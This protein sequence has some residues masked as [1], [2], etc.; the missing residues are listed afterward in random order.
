[1]PEDDARQGGQVQMEGEV[2]AV[3]GDGGGGDQ[4]AHNPPAAAL[5][6]GVGVEDQPVL[7]LGGDAHPVADP[8]LPGEIQGHIEPV[9]PVGADVGDDVVGGVV[10]A[11]PAEAAGVVVA[12]PEGGMLQIE[13]VGVAE[14]DLMLPEGLILQQVPVHG[15]A[16]VPVAELTE[17]RAHH[18]ELLAGA[19]QHIEVEDPDAGELLPVLPG[20]NVDEGVFLVLLLV[21][22]DGENEALGEGVFHGPGDVPVAALTVD[23][24][25]TQVVETVSHPAQIPFEG[26]AQGLLVPLQGGGDI[27]PGGGLVGDGDGAGELLPDQLVDIP[28]QADGLQILG[29]KGNVPLSQLSTI[30]LRPS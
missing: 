8:V 15:V 16:P 9:L 11:D 14:V 10:G 13:L 30:F 28:Q 26:E 3:A 2:E 6:G 24:V 21:V 7:P 18:G 27:G 23:A 19:G 17:L 25:Q 22:G 20:H 1:M 5:I 12:G 29:V 4:L